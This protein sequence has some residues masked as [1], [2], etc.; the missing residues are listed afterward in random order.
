MISGPRPAPGPGEARIA[1]HA[2]GICAS[3]RELYEGTRQRDYVRYPVTPGH[4]WSGTV[5]AV[6]EGVDPALTGR[7]TV[8]EGFRSCLRCER[9]REGATSL[10]LSGYEETGFTQPGAFADSLVLPARLLHPLPDGADLH[11]AALLEPAA[12]AAAAVLAGRARPGDRVAVVGAGTLGL[13][14]VQLLAASTP[15][16]LLAVDPRTHHAEK[17]LGMGA[18]AACSPDEAV[19]ERGGYDVVLETA[20]APS[21]ANDACLLARRGGRVVLVGDFGSGA[22]GV[23]PAHLVC[24]QLTVRAVFGAPPAAWSYA[25]RAFTG[26]LFD[27]GALITHEF[28]LDHFGEALATVRDQQGAGKVLLLP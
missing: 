6:G 12:V 4:E 11:A 23:D 16:A 27:P 1:V 14:A 20:G 21:T 19:G 13:L 18:S 15:G 17:A 26:G 3:D 5:D 28:P 2:A 10:C 9:C 7:K 22:D 25:V 24:A 8:G